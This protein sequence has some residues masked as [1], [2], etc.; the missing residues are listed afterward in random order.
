MAKL[1]RIERE[2]AVSDM[3]HRVSLT[4]SNREEQLYALQQSIM[5]LED[6][7]LRVK[8]VECIIRFAEW[9]FTNQFPV[10]DVIDQLDWAM[11]VVIGL[12]SENRGTVL[13]PIEE[14]EEAKKSRSVPQTQS[15]RTRQTT[16][17][18]IVS[19][20]EEKVDIITR[21]KPLLAYVEE[22]MEEVGD[23]GD[24]QRGELIARILVIKSKMMLYS[25]EGVKQSMLL[26]FHIYR[27]ILKT[28]LMNLDQGASS[29]GEDKPGTRDGQP[30]K[31]GKGGGGDAKAKMST[32][33]INVSLPQNLGEWAIFSLP[34]NISEL[35]ADRFDTCTF[36]KLTFPQ[37]ELSFH[38][39]DEL[40]RQ[41]SL[42]GL[43]DQLL[44]LYAVQEVLS[45][46]VLPNPHL[47][48]LVHQK[49][50][51][52]CQQ[53][54]LF[55]GFNHHLSMVDCEL[56][57]QFVDN[58]IDHGLYTGKNKQKVPLPMG[59][60][61]NSPIR[62]SII[63]SIHIHDIQIEKA[64][65]LI[66]TGDF[67]S[68]ITMLEQVLPHLEIFEESKKRY[69]YVVALLAASQ[70][71]YTEALEH[72]CEL[73]NIP[74]NI[75]KTT[76]L[77]MT[78][79]EMLVKLDAGAVPGVSEKLIAHLQ[80]MQ[81]RCK[82][83]ST[84]IYYSISQIQCLSAR[85]Q[86]ETLIS[87]SP[88]LSSSGVE[89]VL[90]L[91]QIYDRSIAV[92]SNLGF[93]LE[94]AEAMHD[95][96]Q[97]KFQLCDL[98]QGTDFHKCM[99]V[100]SV[101]SS[102]GALKLLN[103]EQAALKELGVSESKMT[104]YNSAL[105]RT[106]CHLSEM[107]CRL[108]CDVAKH[109]KTVRIAD[110]KK[111]QID[112]KIESYISEPINLSSLDERWSKLSF[113][114]ME[115]SRSYGANAVRLAQ[116]FHLEFDASAQLALGR[117]LTESSRDYFED[118]LDVWDT[119]VSM[120]TAVETRGV[121]EE[122]SSLRYL[123]SSVEYLSQAAQISLLKQ[124][125]PTLQRACFEI[126]SRLGYSAPNISAQYIMLYQSSQAAV[127]LKSLLV[128]S[129]HWPT[130]SKLGS[131]VLQLQETY[132]AGN[133][134]LYGKC[135]DELV[136]SNLSWRRLL[137]FENH[138]DLLQEMD[139]KQYFL[140]LQHSPCNKYLFSSLVQGS[141][142]SGKAPSEH[143]TRI[144][145]VEVDYGV[146]ESVKRMYEAYQ[147][148]RHRAMIKLVHFYKHKNQVADRKI[149][150]DQLGV[151]RE[152]VGSENFASVLEEEVG[153]CD[154]F[155]HRIISTLW[156]YLEPAITPFL[157]DF[158]G[159]LDPECSVVLLADI[160]LQELPLE[161]LPLGK[162]GQVRNLT[163]DLSLQTFHHRIL[164]YAVTKQLE[165]PVPVDA[166][167]GAKT[168]VSSARGERSKKILEKRIF[169]DKLPLVPTVL[170]PNNVKYVINSDT[171]FSCGDLSMAEEIGEV[172]KETAAKTGRWSGTV[173]SDSQCST[174]ELQELLTTCSGFVYCGIGSLSSLLP[175]D[176]L[177]CLDLKS[178][179]LHI[180]CD[181]VVS[182]QTLKLETRK[183][184]KESKDGVL[185]PLQ[186]AGL[187]YLGGSVLSL[188][189]LHECS[190][191]KNIT[192]LG[193]LLKNLVEK[194]LK[195]RYLGRGQ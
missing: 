59:L 140:V 61:E 79:L 24:V 9:L 98:E 96:S 131:L 56:E 58:I 76:K 158:K 121:Q 17:S 33:S 175:S 105:V 139:E 107:L 93:T 27:H 74:T 106:Y 23:I 62:D 31:K 80:E 130:K 113:S 2:D 97:L 47:R 37:P 177:S 115:L 94:A 190:S 71:N 30:A 150:L 120:E 3:W 25:G 148:A 41:L 171:T 15:I 45:V 67:R 167:K 122:V 124:D 73:K 125:H 55:Q 4:S 176:L 5:L 123:V 86:I 21:P 173:L 104:R 174:V 116:Q 13:M 126:I 128:E 44:P 118:C 189:S 10:R 20:N 127:W 50:A 169:P 137:L 172:L 146:L 166:K 39:I 194:D 65:L 182:G 81:T 193:S 64:E 188:V 117:A 34:E 142:T 51:V 66:K 60:D 14:Q 19:L 191:D 143:L 77:M 18:N 95:L 185:S 48:S 83:N 156:E 52:A 26:A 151:S 49:A 160:V 147:I 168:P 163:R 192:F 53:L 195:F 183:G 85:C 32:K 112:K 88:D 28:C 165:N 90:D 29:G 12:K 149:L 186:L 72:L 179:N 111:C 38:Y 154:A 7:N 132:K 1:E 91:C 35:L 103:E 162:I 153:K 170:D 161:A 89:K 180:V 54:Q 164:S 101:E 8:K 16:S 114:A 157:A 22:K 68:A 82:N 36:N 109:N 129:L 119:D 102:Q 69:T 138:L 155:Y 43:T 108:A 63:N 46:S 100:E 187:L 84:Q 152:E 184:G 145:R 92:F 141:K 136:K 159:I 144:S 87:S 110:S 181:K 133:F 57:Q 135:F 134:H 40:C 6:P 42:M 178:C 99:F 75:D 11:D 78:I 70:T